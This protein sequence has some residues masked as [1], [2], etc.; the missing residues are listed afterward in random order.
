MRSKI[1]FSAARE[2]VTD[3]QTLFGYT[4]V[5]I[6]DCWSEDRPLFEVCKRYTAISI[7]VDHGRYEMNDLRPRGIVGTSCSFLIYIIDLIRNFDTGN[8]IRITINHPQYSSW[9]Q[10]IHFRSSMID[11]YWNNRYMY[12][13]TSDLNWTGWSEAERNYGRLFFFPLRSEAA[14]LIRL[15]SQLILS[16]SPLATW[17]CVHVHTRFK[18]KH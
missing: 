9:S 16:V 3:K 10:I 5:Y 12:F 6:W 11:V 14:T 18:I 1:Y 4:V 2:S 8:S 15:Y 13:L 7:N 17:D